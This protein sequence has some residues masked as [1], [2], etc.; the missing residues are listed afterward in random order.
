MLSN[1]SRCLVSHSYVLCRSHLSAKKRVKT[2]KDV[3]P[4]V[5][6]RTAK[7]S[8]AYHYLKQEACNNFPSPMMVQL[9]KSIWKVRYF[10][11]ACSC[12]I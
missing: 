1:T 4:A 5:S 11:G 6:T 8:D 7:T 10:G 12:G 9:K 3:L 2:Q